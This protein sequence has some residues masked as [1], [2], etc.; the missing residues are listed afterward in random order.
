MITIHFHRSCRF[1][2]ATVHLPSHFACS[3]VLAPIVTATSIKADAIEILFYLFLLSLVARVPITIQ[4]FDQLRT[5]RHTK[6]KRIG[7]GFESN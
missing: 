3:P 2:R 5:T 1:A 4:L 6:S 7:D